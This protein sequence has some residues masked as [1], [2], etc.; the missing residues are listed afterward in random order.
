MSKKQLTFL[1]LFI[2]VGIP[3]V[4]TN[5]ALAQSAGDV[6]QVENFIRNVIQVIAGL[7]G[8]IATGFFV[9]GGFGYITSS[10]NPETLEKSKRTLIFSGL[11]LAITIGAFVL[12]N[13]VTGIATNAFGR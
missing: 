4:L 8:L 1:S 9:V 7:A 3:F 12:S 5:T 11:G 2:S 6:G 13:I 10:G